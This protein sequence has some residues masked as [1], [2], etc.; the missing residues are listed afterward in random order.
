MILNLAGRHFGVDEAGRGCCAGPFYVAAVEFPWEITETMFDSKALTE[1]RREVLTEHIIANARYAVCSIEPE[2][3][4]FH[5]IQQAQTVGLYHCIN[6]LAFAETLKPD[7]PP[8]VAADG[9]AGSWGLQ[10]G[11]NPQWAERLRF[12]VKADATVAAVSAASILAKTFRDRFMVGPMHEK[13][14]EYGFNVHKGYNTPQHLAA[15]DK[16]G[17]CAIHRHK[18][19]NVMEV[20]A[21]KSA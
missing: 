15:L 18:Y 9:N 21:R 16:F 10:N 1:A 12:V 19:K 20:D 11:V 4:D 14:P 3:I 8:L 13:Y 7:Y 5:G 2:W 17:S 6:S